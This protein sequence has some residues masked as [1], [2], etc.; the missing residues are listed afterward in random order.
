MTQLVPPLR[1]LIARYGGSRRHRAHGRASVSAN[2]ALA[3]TDTDR[4]GNPAG[5]NRRPATPVA[6]DPGRSQADGMGGGVPDRDSAD[7][8]EIPRQGP[9]VTEAVEQDQ[10]D[11]GEARRRA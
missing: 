11:P 6:V 9:A 1:Q 2:N 8:A 3:G 7:T 10:A 4:A 5:G